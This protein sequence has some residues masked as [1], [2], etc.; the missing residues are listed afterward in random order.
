M[1]RDLENVGTLENLALGKAIALDKSSAGEV[2]AGAMSKSITSESLF[3]GA[4]ELVISHAGGEY[5]LRLTNQGKLILT[6]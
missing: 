5:R 1:L 2:S 6:K 4:R 3:A